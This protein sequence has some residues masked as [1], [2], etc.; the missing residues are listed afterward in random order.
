MEIIRSYA[1]TIWSLWDPVYYSFTRLTYIEDESPQKCIFRVRLTKYKGAPTI[2]NDGTRINKNDLMI[3]IH[4]HNVRLIKEMN[5]L[6][7]D[8]QKGIHFYRCVQQSMPFLA[9]YVE[10]HEQS[11]EIKGIIGITLLNQGTQKL[12]FESFSFKSKLY[13][14]FKMVA[15]LPISLVS[16][17]SKDSLFGTE[18]R[19]LMMSK[20]K[21]I[22]RY[23]LK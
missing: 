18:P 22:G 6:K 16:N 9:A 13:R 8:F 5:H 1:M 4:L 14:I 2:L 10:G 7:N 15:L 17:Q 19:Y 23:N 21:L 11:S 20:D 12:G 3:K